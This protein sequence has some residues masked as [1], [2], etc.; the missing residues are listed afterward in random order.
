M[1]FAPDYLGASFFSPLSNK[2]TGDY[3]G[4][5][6]NRARFH[7]EARDAVREV[8]PERFPLT[9]RL[10][11]DDLHEDGVKFD[12]SLA[13]IAT[14]KDH[15]LDPADLVLLGRLAPSNPSLAGCSTDVR[16]SPQAILRSSSTSPTSPTAGRCYVTALFS[17]RS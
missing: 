15:G 3:G 9:M 2:R 6:E 1:H 17:Q 10:G 12:D 13:K 14:M 16:P 5:V 8:W 4:G 11:C 7:L